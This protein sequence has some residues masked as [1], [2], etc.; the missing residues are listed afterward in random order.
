MH[1]KQWKQMAVDAN[2]V[3]VPLSPSNAEQSC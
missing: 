3:T 1:I 2:I